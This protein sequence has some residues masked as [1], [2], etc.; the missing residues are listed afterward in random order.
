MYANF[1]HMPK[2]IIHGKVVLYVHTIP[3]LLQSSTHMCQIYVDLYQYGDIIAPLW[4][5]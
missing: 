4:H 5:F 3:L 1:N 2:K